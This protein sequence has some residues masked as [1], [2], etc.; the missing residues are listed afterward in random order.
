MAKDAIAHDQA[1][2]GNKVRMTFRVILGRQE[3]EALAARAIR[4]EKN[5]SALGSTF[6]YVLATL[7]PSRLKPLVGALVRRL[8]ADERANGDRG[9]TYNLAIFRIVFLGFVAFPGARGMVLWTHYG[10]PLLPQN[11]WDPISFYRYLPLAIVTNA[12]LAHSLAVANA[13][14]IGMALVGLCTRWTLSLATVLSLYVFGLIEN[15]GKIDHFH[16]V[17]WIM[18]LL[19][20]G[21]SGRFLSVD[22]IWLAIRHADTGRV[23]PPIPEK[24]A[25]LTLRSCWV[26]IGLVY[27]FPGLAKLHSAMTQGWASPDNLRA[28]LWHKWFELHLYHAGFVLPP[29]VDELPSAML[30]I[31]GT[32]TILFEVGFVVLVLFRGV[33]P[34][35]VLAGLAFHIGNAYFMSIPFTHLLQAYPCLIDWTGLGRRL[36]HLGGREPLIVLY[37]GGCRLCRRT[38]ALLRSFDLLDDLEPVDGLS[39]DPRR[40]QFPNLTDAML[41]H[42]L[43][44]AD[45]RRVA[46]GY[47]AYKRIAARLPILC[48]AGPLMRWGPVSKVGNRIYRRI[49][50]SRTCAIADRQATHP[51]GTPAGTRL[52]FLVAAVL[53]VS[54]VGISSLEVGYDVAQYHFGER[55]PIPHLLAKASWRFTSWPFDVY[56]TFSRPSA[57]QVEIW[58]ARAVLSTGREIAIAPSAYEAVFGHSAKSWVAVQTTLAEHNPERQRARSLDVIRSVWPFE[59][60]EVR[61][62]AVAVNVYTSK[63]T[64]RPP[65]KVIEEKLIET[66]PV[67][68]VVAGEP[69]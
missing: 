15:Q 20:V 26:L 16:H 14:L 13:V 11:V 55:H 54:E 59:P 53:I 33:R 58:E 56:P 57:S 67:E 49:A 64:T 8:R 47:D 17:L 7:V 3:A 38:V 2:D 46:G 60:A 45:G 51:L 63:Y 44:A 66:F 34:F 12:T 32:T 43:Y 29:R 9:W 19:A 40:Q 62:T 24:A 22:S 10:M 4:E 27:L 30:T 42:D 61:E 39:G 25:L 28:L 36:W 69:K 48:W 5:I 21:P 37:D 35:L 52:I 1:V 65:G 41:T 18:A 6:D 68:V 31:A 50:D 23:E